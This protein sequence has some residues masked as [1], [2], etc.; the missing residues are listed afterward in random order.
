MTTAT[1]PAKPVRSRRR[2]TA[3]ATAHRWSRSLH[4]WASMLSMLLVL[5]FAVTGLTANHPGWVGGPRTSTVAG[6]LPAAAHAGGTWD[7]LVVS[8]YVRSSEGVTGTI[9]DHGIDGSQG[10]LGY[11]GPGYEAALFFDTGTGAYTLTTTSYGVVG[12]VNDLHKGRH[13]TPVWNAVIDISAVV[14]TLVALTGLT[15]QLLIERRRTTALVLLGVG[16]AAGVALL[17]L[18]WH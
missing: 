13:T 2:P 12:V 15:L 17:V 4:S 16:V 8:E 14:L 7:L 10:R 9:T 3:K 1:V 18:S 6:T 5:F 11:Q